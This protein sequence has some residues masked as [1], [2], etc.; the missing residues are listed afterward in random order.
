MSTSTEPK[1]G[2][3]DKQDILP[4]REGWLRRQFADIVYVAKRDKKWWLLPLLFVLLVLAALLVTATALGPLAPFI[5][6]FL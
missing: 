2:E 1:G 6:P 5:Y 3:A 4:P